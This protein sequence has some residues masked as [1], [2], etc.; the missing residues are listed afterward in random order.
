M[1]K[2]VTTARGSALNIE[3]LIT[4]SKRPSN[5]VDPASTITQAPKPQGLPRA[6]NLRGHMPAQSGPAPGGLVEPVKEF[7]A[8]QTVKTQPV[9]SEYS[10]A[11]FTQITI[12]QAGSLKTKDGKRPNPGDGAKLAEKILRAKQAGDKTVHGKEA[13]KST[14]LDDLDE[15]I[16]T[17]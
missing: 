13:G 12:D 10:I 11:D 8:E 14:V 17:P 6:L 2:I 15:G 1:P 16:E 3:A 5:F 4:K 9:G 7:V